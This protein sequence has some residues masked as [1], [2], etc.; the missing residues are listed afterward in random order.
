[1]AWESHSGIQ[2][3]FPM[4]DTAHDQ[5]YSESI[6]NGT[7]WSQRWSYTVP[8]NHRMVLRHWMML[9][10]AATTPGNLFMG[11]RTSRSGTGV[12]L[13][14]YYPNTVAISG[15]ATQCVWETCEI[16]LMPNDV[17]AFYAANTDGGARAVQ[18]FV[19]LDEITL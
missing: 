14:Y 7:A 8:A 17:I 4:H 2:A 6:P 16:P 5:G 12:G 3:N 18:V 1:M 15:F 11:L 9:T 13:A 10:I 19:H